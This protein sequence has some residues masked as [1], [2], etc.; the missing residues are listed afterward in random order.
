MKDHIAEVSVGRGRAGRLASGSVQIPMQIAVAYAMPHLAGHRHP[1]HIQ[2]QFG[3]TM[4]RL[5]PLLQQDLGSTSCG[6]PKDRRKSSAI[7][8]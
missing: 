8:A 3:S 5:G 7:A 1:R 4:A 6:Y 2:R